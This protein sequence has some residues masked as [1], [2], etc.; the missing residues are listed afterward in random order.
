[1]TVPHDLDA[2][3]AIVGGVM[4]FPVE[5]GELLAAVNAEDYYDRFLGRCWAA[6]GQ[7]H[8]AG[9]AVDVV[10][11]GDALAQGGEEVDRAR[12]LEL[13]A[14][15]L[16]PRLEHAEVVVRHAAARRLL[17]FTSEVR[18]GLG[19]GEDPYVLAERLRA[20]TGDLRV[21]GGQPEARTLDEILDSP[22]ALAPW[23]VPGLLR[24]DWRVV[25]VG[26]EGSGKSVLLRQ[27]AACAAQGLHPLS[28]DEIEPVRVLV[29]DAENPS[30]AI[31][32]TG[33]RLVVQLRRAVGERY[34]PK[35]V[36]MLL[37]P[38]GLDLR[39]R[40]DRQRVEVELRHHRPD[41]VVAG[42]AYKMASR[43]ANESFEELAEQTHR[44]LD[45]LRT[46]YGFALVVEHHAPHAGPGVGREMRPYGGSSWL[47][48]PEIGVGLRPLEDRAGHRLTRW[49]GDRLGNDWPHEIVRGDVWPWVGRWEGR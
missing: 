1:M 29:I 33:R 37:R 41:L 3:A 12:L 35:R 4:A 45:D 44:V 13:L 18:E 16:R 9:L 40:A 49:R 38:G 6:I 26:G 11:V 31:A 15:A 20:D 25:L 21:A 46:R 36:R 48:W 39:S 23:V 17:A 27:I 42:P 47:R 32:E 7:L 19:R 22:E 5:A 14:N 8:R 43:R 34:D 10:T 2:E 30:G 24:V 28:Y